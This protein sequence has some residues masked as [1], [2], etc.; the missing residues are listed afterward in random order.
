MDYATEVY[1]IPESERVDYLL[2][3][4]DYHLGEEGE[5]RHLDL[6]RAETAIYAALVRREGKVLSHTSLIAHAE[7]AVG[8]EMSTPLPVLICKM[9]AK[10]RD[11]PVTIETVR[12]VGYRAVRG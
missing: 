9:R 3:V 6:T 8:R 1:K 7:H 11:D 2:S 12:G 10:L 5:P 4:L